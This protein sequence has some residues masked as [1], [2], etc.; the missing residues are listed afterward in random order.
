MSKGTLAQVKEI[1]SHPQVLGQCRQWLMKNM[2]KA[3]LIPV[4]STTKAGAI[5]GGKEERGL[6]RLAGRGVFIRA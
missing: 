1:Y 3:H 5:G 6:H 4:V 2:P